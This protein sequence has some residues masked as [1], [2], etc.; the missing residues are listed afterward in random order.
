MRHCGRHLDDEY[1]SVMPASSSATTWGKPM[2]DEPVLQCL[3]DLAD[4]ALLARERAAVLQFWAHERALPPDA[5]AAARVREVLYVA[6]DGAGRIAGVCTVYK[7]VHPRL[8]HAMFHLRAFVA[9]GARRQ[10]LAFRLALAAREHLEAFNARLPEA[11]RALGVLMEVEAEALKH[12]P[13]TRQARWPQ[14]QFS[15]MG[16]TASGAHLRVYYFVDAPL[17]FI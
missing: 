16:R 5:D 1:A 11:E 4:P 17:R 8:E 10:R 7:A 13:L 9:P 12:S 15:F 2:S 14:T 3:W 6:R